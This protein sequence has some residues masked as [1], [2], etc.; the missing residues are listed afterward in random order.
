MKLSQRANAVLAFHGF[1][2]ARVLS[3]WSAARDNLQ[4]AY[5]LDEL[6]TEDYEL[7]IEVLNAQYCIREFESSFVPTYDDEGFYANSVPSTPTQDLVEGAADL[8]ERLDTWYE[9][10]MRVK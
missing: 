5:H 6:S 2:V 9:A 7:G 4:H 10:Y 3:A 1:E 8:V